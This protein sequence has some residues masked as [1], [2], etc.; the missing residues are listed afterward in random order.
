[1]AN[2]AE[3]NMAVIDFL[4]FF[5]LVVLVVIT[6][7]SMVSLK[8]ECVY[9]RNEIVHL[10]NIRNGHLNRIKVISGNINNLSRQDRIEKIAGE[11]YNLFSPEPESL[12]VFIGESE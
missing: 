4:F 8:N 5:G 2:K 3:K 12:I 11:S 1:M 7:I 10:S 9:L 6:L